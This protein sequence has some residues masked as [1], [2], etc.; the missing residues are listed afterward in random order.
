ML[1]VEALLAPASALKSQNH[2]FPAAAVCSIA[3]QQSPLLS[4][5]CTPFYSAFSTEPSPLPCWFPWFFCTASAARSL[6]LC[7]VHCL[8]LGAGHNHSFQFANILSM[9]SGQRWFV[10]R[11]QNTWM[12]LSVGIHLYGQKNYR[13]TEVWH[14]VYYNW[15]AAE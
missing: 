12:Y 9:Y 15:T 6:M 5:C 14:F 2:H 11:S 7:F 3:V 4:N 13:I 10:L 1:W 8:H